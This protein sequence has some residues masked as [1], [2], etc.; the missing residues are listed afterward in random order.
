MT[1]RITERTLT[2]LI[3]R[4]NQLTGS[5]LE[6]STNG[7]VNIGHYHFNHAYGGVCLHRTSNE[8][9]GVN[10]PLFGG[11]VPKREAYG[12]TWAFIRGIEEGMIK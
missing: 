10:V 3:N 7:K 1:T 12:M 4:L 9:G 11:H 6:Y 8:G 2:G 5:P